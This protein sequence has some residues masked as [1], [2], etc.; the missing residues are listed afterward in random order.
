MCNKFIW[1]N[2]ISVYN[3]CLCFQKSPVATAIP[4]V[5]QSKFPQMYLKGNIKI[6]KHILINIFKYAIMLQSGLGN[7]DHICMQENLPP[8]N[9]NRTICMRA[10]INIF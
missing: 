2:V 10:E 8:K 1:T 9:K 7:I 3:T 5:Q 6:W 4:M